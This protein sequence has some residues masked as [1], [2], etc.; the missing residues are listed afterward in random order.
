[1]AAI[2]IAGIADCDVLTGWVGFI[3]MIL[4]AALSEEGAD[5]VAGLGEKPL[6]LAS[7]LQ[8]AHGSRAIAH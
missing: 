4:A 2:L 1:M 5:V 6:R 7:A 3:A 8:R